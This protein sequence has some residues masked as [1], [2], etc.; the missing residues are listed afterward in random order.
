MVWWVDPSWTPSAHQ[1]TLL[2]SLL[3]RMWEGKQ[4][5]CLWVELRTG[6]DHSPITV[7]GNNRLNSEKLIYC[8]LNQS[9]VMKN[10]TKSL[11][12]FPQPCP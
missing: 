8:K 7:V 9:R 2:L 12:I 5:K 10:K 6:K 3:S 1:V 4:D 11:N